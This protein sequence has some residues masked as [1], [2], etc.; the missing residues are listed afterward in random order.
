MLAIHFGI[1]ESEVAV[2]KGQISRMVSEPLEIRTW[3]EAW[4][5]GNDPEFILEPTTH[6]VLTTMTPMVLLNFIAGN[7][8]N[9]LVPHAAENL[10]GVLMFVTDSEEWTS[11]YLELR[12]P[13]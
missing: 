8:S 4:D 3:A 2:F 12:Y 1:R 5:A 6:V 7:F 10:D 11:E 13:G 9:F